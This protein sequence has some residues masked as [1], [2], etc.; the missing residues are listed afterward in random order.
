M[1]SSRRALFPALAAGV[2]GAMLGG[3][4]AGGYSVEVRNESG[5]QVLARIVRD[6]AF[7][8]DQILEQ[9]VIPDGESAELGPVDVAPLEGVTLR[10][11][12][13]GDIGDVPDEHKLRRGYNAF[14]VE[15]G[16]SEDWSGFS[17]R[18]VE[19]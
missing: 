13:P 17:V 1:P 10:I 2:V 15:R 4:C 12:R 5:R 19:D 16:S 18:K 6:R 8:A 7:D 14:V 3:G 11:S 9:E